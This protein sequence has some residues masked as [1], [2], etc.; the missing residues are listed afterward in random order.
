MIS[1]RDDQPIFSSPFINYFLLVLNVVVF[2]WEF[3][4]E[5]QSQRALNPLLSALGIVPLHTLAVLTGQSHDRLATA[6][7]PMLISMLQHASFLFV[8]GVILLLCIFL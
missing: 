7:L 4:V 6:I 8:A 3:T 5:M 2:L 1:L